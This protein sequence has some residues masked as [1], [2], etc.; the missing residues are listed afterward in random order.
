MS[1]SVD[2]TTIL[3]AVI[4]GAVTI[5]SAAVPIILSKYVSDKAARDALTTAVQSS[6]GT[7]QQAVDSS[8]KPTSTPGVRAD[9]EPGVRYVMD[10]APDAVK[11]LKLTPA[12]IAEKIS[13]QQGLRKLALASP[14]PVVAVQAPA[15]GLPP[16][17]SPS[18]LIPTPQS[19]ALRS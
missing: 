6:L 1:M 14:V 4:G 12:L 8:V 5:L 10:H 9:L 19:S 13:A 7:I 2:V 17:L 16:G 11:R 15:P 3:L 18:A